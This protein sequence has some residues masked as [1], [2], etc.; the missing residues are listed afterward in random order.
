VKPTRVCVAIALG[1]TLALSA[2]TGGDGDDGADT[3]GT[4]G[5]AGVTGET[6]GVGPA[7]VQSGSDTV[8]T[9]EY[10]NAGLVAVLRLDNGAGTLE[11]DNGT[12]ADLPD[13]GF[14]ARHALTGART[15][16]VVTD[17]API[18]AGGTGSFEVELDDLT[19]VD[20]GVLGL[21]FGGEDYGLFVRTA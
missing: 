14:Y 8:G 11:V 2:C 7:P 21:L 13:P 3:G 4:G 1:L 17:P 15:D 5:T 19:V 12:D 10:S 18:P 9:Y 20:V 6:G 16:G